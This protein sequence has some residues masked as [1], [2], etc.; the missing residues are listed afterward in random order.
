[1]D[2]STRGW[3]P[4]LSSKLLERI[5]CWANL[6]ISAVATR[7]CVDCLQPA[8]VSDI[9]LDT[10]R[11]SEESNDVFGFSFIA[12]KTRLASNDTAGDLIE[13][14]ARVAREARD[15]MAG[16]EFGALAIG[17]TT[18]LGDGIPVTGTVRF[19]VGAGLLCGGV[20]VFAAFP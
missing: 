20:E 11:R 10:G 4:V 8:G 13:Y 15:S 1:V 9:V 19:V 7:D 12:A 2:V 14:P 16:L 5:M 17:I 6:F 3:S 18:V